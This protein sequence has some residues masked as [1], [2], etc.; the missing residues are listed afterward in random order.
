MLGR[1]HKTYIKRKVKGVRMEYMIGT[2]AVSALI[3]AI[4]EFAKAK[5][6]IKDGAV[7]TLVA[8]LGVLFT[9]VSISIT[10]GYIPPDVAIWIAGI[11]EFLASILGAMGFYSYL[12]RKNIY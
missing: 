7:V 2:I 4:V 8:I 10:Q 11:V 5:L 9:G 6:G 1:F 12:K 3:F